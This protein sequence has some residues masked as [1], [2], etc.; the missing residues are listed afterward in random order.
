M[1]VGEH[2]RPLGSLA[3]EA[4]YDPFAAS[5]D[6][7][8]AAGSA[9][10]VGASVNRIGQDVVDGV[11]DRKLPHDMRT[12]RRRGVLLLLAV[13]PDGSRSLIPASWSDWQAG[14]DDPFNPVPPTASPA[15]RRWRICSAH[16]R[17]WTL[18]SA[19]V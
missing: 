8:T 1:T 10:G 6:R 19:A 2:G 16:G 15:S 13:L 14:A 3:L 17:S 18:S 4:A 12:M 5:L 7:H 9:E 11:V